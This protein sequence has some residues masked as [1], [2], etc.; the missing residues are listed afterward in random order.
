MGAGNRSGPCLILMMGLLMSGTAACAPPRA[1][2]APVRQDIVSDEHRAEEMIARRIGEERAANAPGIVA[3]ATDATLTE[4]AEARARAMAS[5]APFSHQDAAGHTLVNDMVH[6]RL[7][8]FP[9]YIGE[10]IMMEDSGGAAFDADEFANLAVSEWM[11]S[12]GHRANILSPS[13]DRA[14]VGVAVSGNKAY[15]AMVFV[16]ETH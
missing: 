5:S 3:L 16:G 4:I 6:A 14:G 11:K 13:F 1:E 7:G 12:P 8:D 15:A 9:G 10:N 2:P